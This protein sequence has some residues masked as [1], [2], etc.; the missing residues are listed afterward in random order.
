M[1]RPIRRVCVYCASSPGFDAKHHEHAVEF[2]TRLVAASIGLVY[3]GGQRGLMGS[4]A[5][6][7]MAAGGDVIGVIPTSLFPRELVNMNVMK[8]IEVSSMHERKKVMFD[9]SDAFVALPGGFGTLEELFE[10][11]TWSQLGMH[12]KPI[13]VLDTDGYYAPL[14]QFIDN[15]LESGLMRDEHRQ[16][17][18]RVTSVDELLP[19]IDTYQRE[20]VTKW[21]GPDEL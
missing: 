3:G 15:A 19:A 8:F 16:I 17:I 12:D 2:G 9:H 11:V 7:V 14:F 1:D 13:V 20:I 18:A 5:D 4:I 10:V 6:A 21:I